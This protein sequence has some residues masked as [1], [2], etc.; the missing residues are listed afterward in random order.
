MSDPPPALRWLNTAPEG[1]ALSRLQE[2]CASTSWCRAVLANRPF[3]TPEALLAAGDRASA[4]LGGDDLDQAIAGHPPIGRPKPDDPASAR[5]QQGV[6]DTLRGRLLERNLAYQER[7]GHTFLI[8]ATGRTGDQ[9]L[10]ELEHRLTNPPDRER[11]ETRTEL[12]KINRIRLHRMVTEPVT[13]VSTHILDTTAGRPA[14]GVP[15]HLAVRT[16][17]GD[18]A[19]HAASRTDED[20]RC[21]DFPPLPEGARQARLRFETEHRTGGADRFFPEVAVAFTVEPGEHY[22]VPLLLNPYGYCVY[23]GS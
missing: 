1:D 13:T 7:F 16:P 8:C 9:I 18:W 5:E 11:E 12:Q 4:A 14:A 6:Q 10:A 23:R 3:E 2:V 17:P 20:G 21:R 19:P 15:V 22:H